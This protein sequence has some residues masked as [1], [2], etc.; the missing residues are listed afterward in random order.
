MFN[1]AESSYNLHDS[2]ISETQCDDPASGDNSTLCLPSFS[3]EN[4]F[5]IWGQ[6]AW[7]VLWYRM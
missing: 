4:I 7:K 2:I 3:D 1:A 6:H 5:D